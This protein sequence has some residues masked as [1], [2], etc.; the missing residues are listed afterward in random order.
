MA[1]YQDVLS[2]SDV[3]YSIFGHTFLLLHI[4]FKPI[5]LSNDL[6]CDSSIHTLWGRAT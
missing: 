6:K 1:I 4:S 5:V 3:M 2:E